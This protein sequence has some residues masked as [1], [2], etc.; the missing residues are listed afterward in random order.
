M[1]DTLKFI[2]ASLTTAFA[3]IAG[4]L[5]TNTLVKWVAYGL[6]FLQP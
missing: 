6:S 1:I 4:L 2:A 5:V 3:I